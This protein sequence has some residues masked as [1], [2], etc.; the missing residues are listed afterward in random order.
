MKKISL[1]PYIREDVFGLDS[2]SG[3]FYGWEIIKFEIQK[4]W[5]YSMVIG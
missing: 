4:Y 2:S 3:Q 1:L 5:K